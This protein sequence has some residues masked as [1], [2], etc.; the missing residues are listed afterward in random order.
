MDVCNGQHTC[1][2][3][4]AVPL[5]VRERVLGTTDLLLGCALRLAALRARDVFS[6]AQAVR[7]RA[8]RSPMTTRHR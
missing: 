6:H 8:K 5:K 1:A 2:R 4:R 3:G 7:L